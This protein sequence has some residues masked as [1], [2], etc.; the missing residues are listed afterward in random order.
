MARYFFNVVVPAMQLSRAAGILPALSMS[1]SENPTDRQQD[2]NSKKRR[3]SASL[4]YLGKFAY[5][6]PPENEIVAVFSCRSDDPIRID[7]AESSEASFHRIDHAE[8][9]EA[10]FHTRD[11]VNVMAACETAAPMAY[12]GMEDTSGPNYRSRVNKRPIVNP[13]W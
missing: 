10:S 12:K 9:S 1:R 8:S 3:V 5:H 11:D 2:A 7:H 13:R 4:T 6:V